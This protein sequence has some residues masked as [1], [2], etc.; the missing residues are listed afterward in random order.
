M[1]KLLCSYCRENEGESQQEFSGRGQSPVSCPA[2]TLLHPLPIF[3]LAW[4]RERSSAR[5]DTPK[6]AG[7]MYYYQVLN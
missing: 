2:E 1:N 4:I 5:T 6:G 3:L 7:E